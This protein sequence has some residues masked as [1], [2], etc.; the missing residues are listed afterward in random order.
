MRMSQEAEANTTTTHI[1]PHCIYLNA[2]SV[3]DVIKKGS[4]TKSKNSE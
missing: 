2:I 4:K 3:K 1:T